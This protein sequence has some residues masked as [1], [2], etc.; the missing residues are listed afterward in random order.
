MRFN[1]NAGKNGTAKSKA[2]NEW[3][4]V[5]KQQKQHNYSK[6][7]TPVENVYQVKER[8][9]SIFHTHHTFFE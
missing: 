8:K 5:K 3:T 2:V 1:A 9:A 6:E 4:N 7:K